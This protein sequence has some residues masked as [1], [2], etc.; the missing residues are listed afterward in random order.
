FA[1]ANSIR[2]SGIMQPIVAQ[3]D[4]EIISGERRWTAALLAGKTHERVIFRLAPEEQVHLMR[5]I[6]NLHRSNLNVAE[7]TTA[8]R[9]VVIASGV[10]TGKLAPDNAEIT[11]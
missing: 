3:P 10:V 4:G 1:L 2:T 5:L 8:V 9:Q 7:I 11:V 6:E